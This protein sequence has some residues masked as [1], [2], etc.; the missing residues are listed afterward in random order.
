[1]QY[2]HAAS[3]VPPT[4][5]T[6]AL[7]DVDLMFLV[8][9][10]AATHRV[11]MAG[12]AAGYS[13]T[14][15]ELVGELSGEHNIFT[16]PT[17]LVPDA[18]PYRWR[19]DAVAS[20]GAVTTGSEW[21]FTVK[22]ADV[23]CAS[24]G[25]S[26]F[27]ASCQS[28]DAELTLSGGRCAPAGGCLAGSW[29][30][31]ATSS[32]YAK[33]GSGCDT[34]TWT[35]SYSGVSGSQTDTFAVESLAGNDYCDSNGLGKLWITQNGNTVQGLTCDNNAYSLVSSFE[36]ISCEVGYTLDSS[37][38]SGC[39]ANPSRPRPP[40]SPP[41][42]PPSSSPS[43]PPTG[44]ASSSPSSSPPPS[45]SPNPPPPP[46]PVVLS[47]TASGSV[48]DYSDTTALAASIASLAG[49]DASLVTIE[50][51]A[52]SVVIT[53][54]IATPATTTATAVESSLTSALS[55]AAAA[56]TALG[57]TVEDVPTVVVAAP[58]S[59]PPSPVLPPP[60]P[61]PTL[62]PPGG[63]SGGKNTT[64][65]YVLIGAIAGGVVVLAAIAAAAFC[66]MKRPSSNIAPVATSSGEKTE[67]EA[68]KSVSD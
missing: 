64:A 53:A 41:S 63:P 61:S 17:L 26:P 36:C 31:A 55:T 47:M 50:V 56:S 12:P 49:V 68:F 16:P 27:V 42:P 54:T 40:P 7:P 57:I 5:A 3:P 38:A 60:S 23:G 8:G 25:A 51:T 30:L 19:V 18:T 66:M 32:V 20:D 44:G 11:Y 43:P 37:E 24:C 35:C 29:S 14:D 4:G 9:K 22:C 34:S 52:G 45:P 15:L 6:G 67:V 13:S 59:A 2:T 1:V 21:T 33:S 58:P 62:P 39:A 65:P 28:C 48:S 10:G 46:P